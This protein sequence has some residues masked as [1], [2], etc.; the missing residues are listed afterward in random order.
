MA[1]GWNVTRVSDANDTEFLDRAI[2]NFQKTIDR[3]TL[4]IVDSH[5]AYG[6]PNKQDTSGAH[7]TTTMHRRDHRTDS[8][9]GTPLGEEEIKLAKRFYKWP[10]DKKFYVP[11]NLH[12]C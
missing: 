8:C 4:I 12:C 11:G 7:G 2:Q 1:Y 6:A 10:E 9:A 5:I 3:P